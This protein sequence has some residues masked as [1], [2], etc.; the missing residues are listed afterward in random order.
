MAGLIAIKSEQQE[1]SPRLTASNAPW[2][3]LK[4][5]LAIFGETFQRNS[6][7]SEL[8]VIA[9]ESALRGLTAEQIHAACERTLQTW[10]FV[11]MPPPAVI[12]EAHKTLQSTAHVEGRRWF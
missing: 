1:A 2:Q 11:A 5:W 3:S 10:T 9:Y 4:R 12:L 7:L 8:Q 6:S